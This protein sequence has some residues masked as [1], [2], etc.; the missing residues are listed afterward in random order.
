MVDTD[1]SCPTQLIFSDV[2]CSAD[3]VVQARLRSHYLRYYKEEK[4]KSICGKVTDESEKEEIGDI[5]GE[6]Q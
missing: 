3:A 5:D 6:M 2:V 1:W 4:E